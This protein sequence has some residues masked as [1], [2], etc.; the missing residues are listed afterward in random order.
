VTKS[1]ICN[2]HHF[3]SNQ[4]N[5]MRGFINPVHT[6]FNHLQPEDIYRGHISCQ[7]RSKVIEEN[8][9]KNI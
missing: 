2:K 6:S 4:S 8:A 5:M 1:D 9:L 3:N 7:P